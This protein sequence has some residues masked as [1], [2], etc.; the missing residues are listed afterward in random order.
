MLFIEN[1]H[2]GGKERQT[3]SA[4]ANMLTALERGDVIITSRS[5]SIDEDDDDEMNATGNS[6]A[7]VTCNRL[8]M[9]IALL[10]LLLF[11]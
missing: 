9:T 6:N 3:R 2:C 7:T 4:T 5:L 8:I 11:M 10:M 1:V